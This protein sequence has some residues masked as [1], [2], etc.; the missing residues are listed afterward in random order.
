[1]ELLLLRHGDAVDRAAW[2]DRRDEDRPLTDAGR[3][4][5]RA[6]ARALP[7]LGAVPALI[8][9]SPLLRAAQTAAV[10]AEV[11]A[12]RDE[13]RRCP[14][15]APGGSPE[16]VLAALAAAGPPPSALLVG[17]TPDLGELAAWLVWGRAERPLPLRTGGL[18]RLT[19]P[20]PPAPATA[21]LRWL[22]PPR[23]LRAIG[24][25]A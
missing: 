15:L 21:D 11:L 10:V 7:A 18:L 5:A 3:A 14:P 16:A 6:A 23:V 17:H 25:K 4:E 9:A 19:L 1:M 24:R 20:D 2:G 12:L 22:L 8:L 13:V